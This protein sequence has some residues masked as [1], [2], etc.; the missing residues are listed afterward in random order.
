M[1]AA[2]AAGL[3]TTLSPS[4]GAAAWVCYQLLNGAAQGLIRQQP[5]TA[6]QAVISK[7]QLAIAMSLVTFCQMLGSALFISFG[8]T[9]FVN[10]LTSSLGK[11]APEVNATK[12]LD[13]GATNFRTVVPIDSVPGVIL[14]YNHALTT[15]FVSIPLELIQTCLLTQLSILLLVL[16]VLH[17]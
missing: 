17:L 2:V 7:D 3:L 13:V 1:L 9:A 10:S 6:V 14:A 5:I 16:R 11:Y 15:T 12:V 4:S 8:Q